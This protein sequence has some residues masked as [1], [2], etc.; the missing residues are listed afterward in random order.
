[1]RKFNL[2]RL[3]VAVL[4]MVMMLAMPRIIRADETEANDRSSDRSVEVVLGDVEFTEDLTM[5]ELTSIKPD[6]SLRP[7]TRPWTD[8]V[9]NLWGVGLNGV[10]PNDVEYTYVEKYPYT[11][12]NNGLA[13]RIMVQFN[14]VI[15]RSL[16]EGED[17]TDPNVFKMRSIDV[18]GQYKLLDNN[19]NVYY[20]YCCDAATDANLTDHYNG[21]NL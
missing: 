10:N 14:N 4:C 16:H 3:S 8:K 5:H 1:M 6:M 11:L 15:P 13:S 21:L 9:N 17:P 19:G 12:V 18:P 7:T 2:K 20:T